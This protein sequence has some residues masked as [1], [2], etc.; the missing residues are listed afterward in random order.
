MTLDH[1]NNL[2]D[3]ELLKEIEA[4]P[5]YWDTSPAAMF[6]KELLA[7]HKNIRDELEYMTNENKALSDDH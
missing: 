4:H 6:M 5:C 1:L 2:S 7:R 3:A